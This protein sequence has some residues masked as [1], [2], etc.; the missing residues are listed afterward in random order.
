MHRWLLWSRCPT[1]MFVQRLPIYL[2]FDFVRIMIM[3]QTGIR[4]IPKYKTE[5]L[6]L[7]KRIGGSYGAGVTLPHFFLQTACS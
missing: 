5:N 2:K 3:R 1:T 7:S 6:H 4:D